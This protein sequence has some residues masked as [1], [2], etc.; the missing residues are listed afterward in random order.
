MKTGDYIKLAAGSK[1][2]TAWLSVFGFISAYLGFAGFELMNILLIMVVYLLGCSLYIYVIRKK[3]DKPC[4]SYVMH[5][6]LMGPMLVGLFITVI[7]DDSRHLTFFSIY[8]IFVIAAYLVNYYLSAYAVKLTGISASK[9][10]VMVKQAKKQNMMFSMWLAAFVLC[11]LLVLL[12]PE[13]KA[14]IQLNL[15]LNAN[16]ASDYEGEPEPPAVEEKTGEMDSEEES[17]TFL[18]IVL[19][20]FILLV[21]VSI[22]ILGRKIFYRDDKG[23][24]HVLSYSDD[25]EEEIKELT[26][27]KAVIK[28]EEEING[29][30]TMRVRKYFARTVKSY[31]PDKVDNSMTPSQLL[32]E[33]NDMEKALSSIYEAARYSGEE[34]SKEDVKAAR[35]LSGV[36]I[37]DAK[38]N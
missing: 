28:R 7:E 24:K 30:A 21:V 14:K 16:T 25:I 20:V 4:M 3:L 8:L 23:E 38:K 26:K 31:Y 13:I 36:L 1:I 22:I 10:S 11:A 18:I 19:A 32:R 15:D 6:L 9:A 17:N 37:K 27:T 34:S 33:E 12:V 2:I 35:A 29:S 5:P